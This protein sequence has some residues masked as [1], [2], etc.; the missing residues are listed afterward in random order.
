[1]P[2]PSGRALR[3]DKAEPRFQLGKYTGA[4]G[5]SVAAYWM[6]HYD[7]PISS[8]GT[9]RSSGISYQPA[10]LSPDVYQEM[11]GGDKKPRS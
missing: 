11:G 8:S 7:P 10:A 9:G 2:R 1:M 6:E 4:I 5:S 3:N